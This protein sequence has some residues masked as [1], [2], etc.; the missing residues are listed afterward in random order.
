[1]HYHKRYANSSSEKHVPCQYPERRQPPHFTF[2]VP[3]L[4]VVHRGNSCR[5]E[6]LVCRLY[7]NSASIFEHP[8]SWAFG[9]GGAPQLNCLKL[10]SF[11]TQTD[12]TERA[13]SFYMPN[14]SKRRLDEIRGEIASIREQN[15]RYKTIH[16]PTVNSTEAQANARTGRNLRLQQLKA[17]LQAMMPK[18]S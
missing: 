16:T 7:P 9:C 14:V 10:L 4:D 3:I 2:G 12:K 13:Y 11:H 15:E 8:Q 17:E 18:A 6:I 5:K 1:M